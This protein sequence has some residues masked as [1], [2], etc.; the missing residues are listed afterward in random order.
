M[1]LGTLKNF[2]YKL[3]VIASWLLAILALGKF[4]RNP[5]F[6]GSGVNLYIF[7][8]RQEGSFK[9]EFIEE[10]GGGSSVLLP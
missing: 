8:N 6:L 3:I 7:L 10:S 5:P 1:G 2:S 9:K 4:R